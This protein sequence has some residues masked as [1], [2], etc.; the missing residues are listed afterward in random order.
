MNE[1]GWALVALASTVVATNV[2]LVVVVRRFYKRIRRNLALHNA[3]LRVRAGITRGP[4]REVLALRLRLSETLT[5]ARAA[6]DLTRGSNGPHG[7]LPLLFRRLTSEGATIESQL[8][9]LESENDNAVLAAALPAARHRVDEIA[10][11]VR[12]LRSAVEFGLGDSSGD[13]LIALRSDV[14]REVEA[15][16]AG[17]Q[18]L[19]E[20]N[21][22]G[23]FPESTKLP[24][25]EHSV[26]D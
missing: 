15:M 21:R 22:R 9:F 6:I 20:L 14:D 17:M 7:E 26:T 10:A 3:G 2:A 24:T 1:L 4:H 13:S 25:T 8:R 18:E 23:G 16:H 5:S 19:R 12:R 11:L